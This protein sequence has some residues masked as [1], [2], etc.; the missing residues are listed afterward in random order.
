MGHMAFLQD[1]TLLTSLAA[2]VDIALCG[3]RHQPQCPAAQHS[4]MSLD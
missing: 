3:S 2:R 1:G 4:S